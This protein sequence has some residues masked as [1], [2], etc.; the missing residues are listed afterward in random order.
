MGEVEAVKGLCDL[1][2]FSCGGGLGYQKELEEE[3]LLI[4]GEADHIFSAR[5][6]RS[7]LFIV[8]LERI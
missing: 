1:T 8:R 6:G 2:G 3:M 4:R 5:I 7:Y